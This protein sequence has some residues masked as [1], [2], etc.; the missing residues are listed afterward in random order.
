MTKEPKLSKEVEER[1]D[2]RFLVDT[3]R[4]SLRQDIVDLKYFL[5]G[6]IELA[7]KDIKQEI[8]KIGKEIKEEYNG[9]LERWEEE[10]GVDLEKLV[11]AF[12]LAIK[13]YQDK[14]EK[15]EM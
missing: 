9:G 7:R 5:G 12:N 1:F 15:Y 4:E 10:E 3:I 11:Y 13:E 6:E 14:I 8:K 2:E